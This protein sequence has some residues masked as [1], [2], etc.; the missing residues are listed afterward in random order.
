MKTDFTPSA[1][2]ILTA[3]VDFIQHL[4]LFLKQAKSK[5]LTQILWEY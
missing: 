3:P 2:E 5:Q 4:G 1:K